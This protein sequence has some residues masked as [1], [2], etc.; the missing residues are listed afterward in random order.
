MAK[1]LKRAL[2]IDVLP[3]VRLLTDTEV[4][5]RLARWTH[6]IISTRQWREIGKVW[7]PFDTTNYYK[8]SAG[9]PGN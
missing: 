5:L 4:L 8:M 3:S 1:E 6:T 9:R 2:L 7:P